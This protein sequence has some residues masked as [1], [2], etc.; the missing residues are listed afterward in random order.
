MSHKKESV[1]MFFC[2][3]IKSLILC[4]LC[5]A[6]FLCGCERR[7]LMYEPQEGV[8]FRLTPDWSC[9]EEGEEAPQYMKALFFPVDGGAVVERFIPSDGSDIYVPEG[10]YQVILYNWRTNESTQTV[11]FRGDTYDT[12][13]AYVSPRNPVMTTR[14][15]LSRLPHPDRQLYGWNTG[16]DT[17]VVAGSS[18][19]VRTRAA[20][21]DALTAPMRS[22]VRSYLVAVDVTHAEYLEGISGVVTDVYSSIPLGGGSYGEGRYAM[23]APVQRASTTDGVTRYYCRVTTFGFF[24]DSAKTLD[25]TVTNTSGDTQRVSLDITDAVGRVDLGQAQGDSPQVVAPPGGKP[26]D[27][28]APQETPSGPGGG[29]APPALS[30]WEQEYGDI[31]L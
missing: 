7:E 30:E 5:G 11:Q 23:E 29:F 18:P 25:L 24:D 1:L 26:V 14:P 3:R 15:D 31:Y 20:S 27:V 4:L 17:L 9:L 16:G 8:P 13:E 19:V 22:L 28:P 12:F 21:G 10:E 2:Q 6:L